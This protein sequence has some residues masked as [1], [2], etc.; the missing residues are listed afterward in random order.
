MGTAVLDI[1]QG[2]SGCPDLREDLRG[3][4]L[5]DHALRVGDVGHDTEH[6]EVWG[7]IPTQSGLKDDGE[8]TSEMMGR[9]MGV[10]SAGGR[11]G[12]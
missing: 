3:S 10:Y 8:T 12:I 11:D 6:R 7:W 4:G 1:E 2:G 5:G 9:W